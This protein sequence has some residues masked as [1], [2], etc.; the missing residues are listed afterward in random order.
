MKDVLGVPVT[1]ASQNK[2]SAPEKADHTPAVEEVRASAAPKAAATQPAKVV[3]DK[4]QAEP[5]KEG[6]G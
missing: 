4:V 6:G 1:L 2:A 5:G 3:A